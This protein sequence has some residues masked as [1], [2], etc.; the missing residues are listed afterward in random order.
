MSVE[1]LQ[2]CP[3]SY[4]DPSGVSVHV[5]NISE[6]LARRHRVTVYATNPGSKYPQHEVVNGVQVERFRREGP[7]EAYAFSLEMLLKLHKA[8]FEILHSHCYHALPMHF[9]TLAKRKRFV[10]T[11]HFHGVGHSSFRNSLLRLVKPM[12]KR[13]LKMA[14]N[15]VAVSEYEKSLICRQFG[16]QSDRV[17]VIPNGVDFN[18]FLDLRRQDHES[19]TILHVGYL[20]AHKGAQYLIEV[21]PR[22]PDDVILEIVGEG[23]LKPFLQKRIREL[24]VQDRVVF[25][26]HLP[27]QE[28]L[29]KY[30]NA[31]V[32]ILLSTQEAY[33]LVVAEALV[34]G[35][36][37]IVANTSALSEW[38]DNKS[39]F[40]VSVPVNLGELTKLINH[41]LESSLGT[42]G[43]DRQLMRKW[44]GKKIPDWN[45]VANRLEEIYEQ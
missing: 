38:V 18:E 12:G 31:D 7:S 2:V 42:R 29:Q 5:Q 26:H 34:A 20:T 36:P 1:I 13:T 15:I 28:L 45:D 40:G 6:R 27:R 23:P 41:V 3:F 24:R 16:F 17:V 43:L 22:L 9:S 35:T 44:I 33:A 32:F 39:C 8:D 37:C 25:Y 30:A 21:L 19:K 4:R 10:V 14:D 11:T